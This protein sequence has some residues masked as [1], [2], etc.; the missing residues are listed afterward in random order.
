MSQH[1]I[2]SISYWIRRGPI[3]RQDECRST[4][5]VVADYIRS[6]EEFQFRNGTLGITTVTFLLLCKNRC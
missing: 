5:D 1:S 2:P 4:E 3:P 6:W